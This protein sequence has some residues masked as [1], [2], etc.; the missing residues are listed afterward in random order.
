MDELECIA[1]PVN[2]LS[3]ISSIFSRS[4]PGAGIEPP[5]STSSDQRVREVSI[6]VVHDDK[7]DQAVEGDILVGARLTEAHLA[8]TAALYVLPRFR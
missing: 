4:A 8:T 1:N 5:S 3:A 7:L 6:F 2:G